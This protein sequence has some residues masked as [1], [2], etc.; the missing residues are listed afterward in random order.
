VRKPLPNKLTLSNLADV[1]PGPTSD[2]DGR[3]YKVKLKV[4]ERHVCEIGRVKIGPVE[5]GKTLA[6]PFTTRI[7][8][9]YR[10]KERHVSLYLTS[11]RPRI[12]S[13]LQRLFVERAVCGAELLLSRPGLPIK[14]VSQS[15]RSVVSKAVKE[16]QNQPYSTRG[17]EATFR[18]VY[19]I[20]AGEWVVDP[21]DS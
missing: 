7:S 10:V 17:E 15:L 21:R 16:L 12:K 9:E 1:Q 18:F 3:V 20:D 8:L 6:R 4:G 11:P 14:E 13:L 19:D 5:I 2:A